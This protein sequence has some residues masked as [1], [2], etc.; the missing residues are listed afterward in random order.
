MRD[1]SLREKILALVADFAEERG[2]PAFVP[3]ETYIPAS[4]KVLGVRDL[5]N[6]VDAS[7]DGWLTT[8]RYAEQF[9]QALARR[10]GVRRASLV[11]SGSAA[12]LVAFSA[13]TSR[14]LGDRRIAPG[15]EVIT[16]AAGFP[17]TVAPI[18]QNRCV[19]VFVD[20]DLAT[21]NIDAAL[22]EEARSPA[23]RAVV[24]AHALGNPFDVDAVAGFAKKHGLWLVEDA[25]DAL[26]ATY[27]G[28]NVGAFGDLATLSF[29]PAHHITTG[30][31]GAVLTGAPALAR[32]VE[33]FRDWGRD[34]W[35]AP[36]VDDTCGKRFGW[37]LGGLPE[38]Y[39]HKY[40]YTHL[41]YN[42]KMTDMQAAV[43]CAQLERLD[44]LIAARRANWRALREAFVA[45]RLDEWFLLPE[46]TPR[47]E[48]SWF[49]FVLTRREAARWSRAEIVRYLERARIGTRL[50]FAGNLTKQP[51]FEGVEHRVAGSLE[52]TDRVM[53]DSFWVGVWPGLGPRHIEYMVDTF[54]RLARDMNA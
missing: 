24:L 39:D 8:G 46:A 54:K 6:L 1:V 40:I 22:L 45:E 47:S 28:A 14:Q 7:L 18:V 4:G 21:H 31:G 12:N 9:S 53:R 13:L 35:C 33:S 44:A 15:S 36:G 48:P 32:I 42:V 30:E 41:G 49:G 2:A 23:T 38:G 5:V 52:R 51:A 10:V 26:G 19:P 17:T 29:Y 50:V 27:G 37:R 25:C 34:C 16:V 3:G 20:V 43:G 11:A